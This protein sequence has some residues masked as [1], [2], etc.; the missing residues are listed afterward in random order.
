MKIVSS[1]SKGSKMKPEP[2]GQRWVNVEV[3]AIAN[4]RSGQ[5]G[6]GLDAPLGGREKEPGGDQAVTTWEASGEHMGT[7]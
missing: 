3:N 7:R 2:S 6:N 1:P 5:N 4:R